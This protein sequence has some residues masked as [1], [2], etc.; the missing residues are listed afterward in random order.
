MTKV[1]TPPYPHAPLTLVAVEARFPTA[2]DELPS[3]A[4]RRSIRDALGEDWV[5]TDATSTELEFS[6][7]RPQPSIRQVPAV[8]FVTRDLMVAVTLRPASLVVETTNY[9][10]Y[11]AFREVVRRAATAVDAAS[12]PDGVTRLGLRYIDEIIVPGMR[13]APF[14]AWNEWLSG[15][16]LPPRPKQLADLGLEQSAWNG[17]AS[18]QL[19]A[20]RV[21]QLRW[22][23]SPAPLVAEPP[24]GLRQPRALINEP[25]VFMDF[26]CA[27]TPEDLPAF[28]AANLMK[29]CDTLH[30]P[31][32][33]LFESLITE[34][35]RTEIFGQGEPA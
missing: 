32:C 25:R 22:G 28:S 11:T 14:S 24:G 10:G 1:A 17:Q 4:E 9:P 26:D 16:I 15:D 12:R 19:A 2:G 6:S 34:R 21:L 18:Y 13:D 31:M 27:W 29:E 3:V 35:L 8:R 33:G 5:M 7:D 30:A 20:N 23:Y